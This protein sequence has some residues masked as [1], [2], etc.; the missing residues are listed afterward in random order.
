MAIPH[1]RILQVGPPGS[2]L[3]F[4][5]RDL[6]ASPAEEAPAFAPQLMEILAGLIPSS[7]CAIVMAGV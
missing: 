1:E 5:M 3:L 7:S 4:Q 2:R 6:F